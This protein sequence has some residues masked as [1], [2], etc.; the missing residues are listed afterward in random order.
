MYRQHPPYAVQVELTQGCNLGCSFCGINALGYQKLARGKDLMS[1]ETA[2]SL[3]GQLKSLRWNPRIEFAMH[4]EP[5]LN[6]QA[7]AII[8]EFRR[9][10]PKCYIMMTSNGGGLL[11]RPVDGIEELFAAGLNTLALDDYESVKIVP[12]LLAA[13]AAKGREK[14]VHY[15]DDPTGNPHSRHTGRLLSIV[16]DISVATKGTHSSLN[17]HAGSAAPLNDRGV[18]KRCAKPFRELAVRWDGS[19][20]LCCNDWPGLYRCGNILKEGVDAIWQGEAFVAARQ[21]LIAG[22]REFAPCKGCDAM[23]TRVGLL[24]D[25]RGNEA[26]PPVDASTAKAIKKALAK[27]PY[28]SLGKDP[29]GKL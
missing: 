24:P 27:G 3:A 17:N 4:G 28:T 23:S 10:L 29:R 26:L 7:A 25:P 13:Y 16:K 9:A 5:T 14:I 19:V 1:L 11:T 12:R 6:P 2:R 20:A 18:G 22:R 8:K 15:P 21:M